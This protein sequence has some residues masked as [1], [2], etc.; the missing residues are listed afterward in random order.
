MALISTSFKPP[1]KI[2]MTNS[3]T[4]T[5]NKPMRTP[6]IT[7]LFSSKDGFSIVSTAFFNFFAFA[8]TAFF[9]SASCCSNAY[10]S[11]TKIPIAHTNAAIAQGKTVSTA[12]V[13]S[14]VMSTDVKW[15]GFTKYTVQTITPA[16]HTAA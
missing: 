10:S 16:K 4:P 2:P 15:L 7:F 5:I 8:A 6:A 9:T 11:K 14:P 13:T 12:A 3:V 1:L